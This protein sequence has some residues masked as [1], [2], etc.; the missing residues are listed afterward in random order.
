MIVAASVYFLEHHRFT[1]CPVFSRKNLPAA[2]RHAPEGER[3]NNV[4]W[5]LQGI[6]AYLVYE[7]K[8]FVWI[9]LIPK[10]KGRLVRLGG[11][12]I[13]YGAPNNG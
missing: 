3:Q 11:E 10:G 4:I 1:S 8:V 6:N 2:G 5:D 12:I 13:G 7:R 9:L